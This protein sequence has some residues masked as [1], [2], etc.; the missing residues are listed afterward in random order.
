MHRRLVFI[1]L[2]V[3]IFFIPV[4]ARDWPQWRGPHLNG[5][6]QE[7]GLPV[8]WTNS[9]NIAWKLA[10]PAWTG[11]TPI[12]SGE[13]I[14][15][16]VADGEDISLWAIDRQTGKPIWR[17]QLSDG[18]VKR[19]KQN[20]SSPS[21]VTDGKH[22]WV[23]TGTGILTQFDFDGNKGWTRNIQADYGQFG[24]N[25][26]Y[27]SSPLL[28]EDGLYIPVLHGMRTDDPSYIL[29]VD[30]TTGKTV[31]RVERPT[32]ARR[33]SPDAY[34]TPALLQYDDTTEIVI[35]GGDVVTGHDPETGAELWR[36]DGL[37][38]ENNGAYRL[39]LIHI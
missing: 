8:T 1:I 14:F 10:M 32:N 23:M 20:M 28:Y 19:R 25:W 39:S 9:E 34:I 2:A 22:V 3:S 4:K 33:E 24:L 12:V 31:W 36:A 37:N 16:N 7:T 17:R 21:P 38:P 13:H 15:L 30:T 18:N 35:T 6:S 5:T 26:G 29:R 27:A 11:A